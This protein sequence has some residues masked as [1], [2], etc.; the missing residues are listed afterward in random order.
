MICYNLDKGVKGEN[1]CL[2]KVLHALFC[3]LLIIIVLCECGSCVLM[4]FLCAS[5]MYTEQPF[6]M[7]SYIIAY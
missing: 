1:S 7:I 2:N 5:Y 3:L 4:Q 6:N